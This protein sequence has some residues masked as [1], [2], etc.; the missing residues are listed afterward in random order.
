MQRLVQFSWGI[1]IDGYHWIEAQPVVNRL[2]EERKERFLSPGNTRSWRHY[3]PLRDTPVLF[4]TFADLSPTEDAVRAFADQ[5]GALGVD[6]DIAIP[7]GKTAQH[8]RGE[9]LSI[10]KREITAMM[11]SLLVWDALRTQSV[12]DLSRW[13]HLKD[14]GTFST[15]SYTPDEKWPLGVDRLL[16]QFADN[17]LGDWLRFLPL[18]PSQDRGNPGTSGIAIPNSPV[19]LALAYLMMNVNFR[20]QQHV[21]ISLESL[22]DHSRSVPLDLHVVPKNLLGAMWMQFAQAIQGDVRYQRCPQ[23]KTWFKVPNK[24]NRPSTTFCSPRC[25][26]QAFRGRQAQARDMSAKRVPLAKIARELGNDISVVRTWVRQEAKQPTQS[27]KPGR[28]A[29][30]TGR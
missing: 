8:S 20:T 2:I 9:S 21:G 1:P 26:V 5:H 16:P 29:R 4:R 24:A 7:S 13:F 3:Y 18:G 28:S 10:W 11:H 15:V 30:K 14:E 22:V 6:S 12:D 25:R 17:S 23:C 27:K 19:G